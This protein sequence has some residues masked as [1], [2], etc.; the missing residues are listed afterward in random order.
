MGR[1]A[2]GVRGM[3]LSG[4]GD[5]IIEMS[6]IKSQQAKTKD[7]KP[8]KEY[9]L[10]ISENGY[11]KRT[12]IKEF[13]LQKRGGSGI[14]AAKINAKTG[15]IVFSKIVGEEDYD[16]IVIS[17]KGQVIRSPLKSISTLGR[18]TSGVRVMKLRKGDKVA[19]AICL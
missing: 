15:E 16:L 17:S 7:Q 13:R 4:E 2:A 11:G 9:L 10:V 6:V 8:A 18:A 1:G 14:K 19:S 3:R 12:R 5:E